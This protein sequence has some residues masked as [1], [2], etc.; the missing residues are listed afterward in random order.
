MR[1]RSSRNK[2]KNRIPSEGKKKKEEDRK[3]QQPG[4]HDRRCHGY[5]AHLF[6]LKTEKGI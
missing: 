2:E 6:Q 1:M 3:T 4:R 5:I